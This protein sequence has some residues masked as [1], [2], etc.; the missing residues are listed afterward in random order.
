MA[1]LIQNKDA[2]C[3]SKSARLGMLVL[4]R[5]AN[6]RHTGGLPVGVW[7]IDSCMRGRR[8]GWC[9]EAHPGGAA[10]HNEQEGAQDDG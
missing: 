9:P 7:L 3:H 6:H 4:L 1:S 8:H 5:P 10:G 2:Y